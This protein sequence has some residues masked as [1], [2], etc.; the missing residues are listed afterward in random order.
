VTPSSP[1]DEH[2]RGTFQGQRDR[3]L[4][5]ANGYQV[6]PARSHRPAAG[7]ES[8]PLRIRLERRN[9]LV[10]NVRTAAGGVPPVRSVSILS[11]AGALFCG[12]RFCSSFDETFGGSEASGHS[13]DRPQPDGSR[14]TYEWGCEVR[15]DA[16]GRIDLHSLEPGVA[17]TAEVS[18]SLHGVVASAPFVMPAA[19]E[20]LTV[21]LVVEGTART[22]R[23]RVQARDGTP[24]PD[25]LVRLESGKRAAEVR[26]K[27]DGLFSFE[28]VYGDGPFELTARAAGHAKARQSIPTAEIAREHVLALE[29]G[30]RVLLRIVDHENQLVPVDAYAELPLGE[31]AHAQELQPGELQFTDLPSGIV[32]FS[33]S[34]GG[35]RFTLAHDSANPNAVLRVPR[36][37][38]IVVAAPKGVSTDMLGARVTRLDGTAEPFGV[39][40]GGSDA[41]A[42]L[43][44]PGRYRIDFHR[45][46]R[47]WQGQK[48]EHVEETIASSQ[49]FEAKA[50][51]I[52]RIR[53]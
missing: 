24:L 30:Q 42:E 43:L 1:S 23:G 34:F 14:E 36:P 47:R 45:T 32:S 50:G 3:V 52:V 10:L 31:S 13:R 26:A 22:V 11:R 49:Q 17:C 44:L 29:P 2:G 28:G 8:D 46:V 33:C 19:G 20:T 9:H 27:E 35:N 7:T 39:R 15:P 48:L 37:A 21:D 40:I 5:G 4:I 16:N 25:A 53:F 6:Q 12:K 18:D 51:E 38:R 41:E